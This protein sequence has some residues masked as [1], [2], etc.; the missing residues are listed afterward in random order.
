MLE[1]QDIDALLVGALYGELSPTESTRL[2]EHLSAHPQDRLVLDGLTR[3]RQA[4][5]D[6]HVLVVQAEPPAAVSALLLQ[7]AARRAPAPREERVGFFAKLAAFLRHP[8]TAAAAVVVL[9]A[10]VAGTIYLKN[11]ARSAIRDTAAPSATAA[12]PP[13]AG[14]QP[15]FEREL[16]TNGSGSAAAAGAGSGFYF[17]DKRPMAGDT[18]EN[19]DGY[20]AGI[21]DEAQTG[22]LDRGNDTPPSVKSPSGGRGK[23][24]TPAQLEN[25][26]KKKRDYVEVTTSGGPELKT[27]EEDYADVDD[28]ETTKA[29]KADKVEKTAESPG[30]KGVAQGSATGALI[31]PA[32]PTAPDTALSVDGLAKP[33]TMPSVGGKA[34]GNTAVDTDAAKVGATKAGTTAPDAGGTTGAASSDAAK[35][36]HQRV[37]QLVKANKCKDAA[38]AA[39]SLYVSF[40]DYYAEFVANDR[41]LKACK[42]YIDSERKKKQQPAKSRVR[43][44]PGDSPASDEVK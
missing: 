5:R 42:P 23:D 11:G 4:L 39:G 21:A 18:T 30:R 37:L 24:E 29:P 12:S 25:A 38:K 33:S 7:E 16:A 19:G 15:A 14:E 10:G 22:G 3:A 43:N 13:S 44:E 28:A 34:G 9:V 31:V 35:L 40:P 8:A 17:E 6:S 1:R 2:E 26:E 20:V 32:D 36:Q 41:A 27:L